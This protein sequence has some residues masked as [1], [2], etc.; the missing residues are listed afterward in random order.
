MKYTHAEAYCLMKYVSRD[1]KHVEW[2]WNSRDGVTPFI[3]FDENGEEM[4]HTD[5]FLDRYLPN[6]QPEAGERVFV[7]MT[8]ERARERAAKH[9][10]AH[11]DRLSATFNTK[12]EAIKELFTS[13]YRE[14]APNIITG[15]EYHRR[16][17][18]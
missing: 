4:N 5:F 8:P 1:G 14:G 18:S 6:Y 16:N 9:V 12:D 3:I 11:W 17:P 10:D 2:L 15:E 13:T 7:D